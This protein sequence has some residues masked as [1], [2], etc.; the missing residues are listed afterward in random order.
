MSNTTMSAPSA[1]KRLVD[2]PELRRAKRLA[3]GG[4]FL[5]AVALAI[6]L[7]Q[8]AS[9]ADANLLVTGPVI[10]L[11]ATLA[12]WILR[13][14]AAFAMGL[15]ALAVLATL[16]FYQAGS[17]YTTE[18]L[19]FAIPFS[20]MAATVVGHVRRWS[21]KTAIAVA[22]VLVLMAVGVGMTDM[23]VIFCVGHLAILV[24]LPT[25]PLK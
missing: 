12:G 2:S 21:G 4:T 9:L 19:L 25:A 20:A 18:M 24:G 3:V 11:G 8:E 5:V 6:Q 14:S 16:G 7:G 1:G 22:V 15:A 23:A 10:F 17:P 13:P